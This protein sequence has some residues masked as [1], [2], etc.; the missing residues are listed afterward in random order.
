[1]EVVETELFWA[2]V[3]DSRR[4]EAGSTG[5]DERLR[6]VLLAVAPAELVRFQAGMEQVIAE[7]LTWNLW[8]AADR[9]FGGWCSDDTFAYFQRWLT[10][11]GRPTFEAVVADPDALAYVPEVRCLGGRPREAWGVA[12]PQ[13]ATLPDLA[14]AVYVRVT[15]AREE[16]FHSA[17][18]ALRSGAAARVPATPQGVRWSALDEPEAAR[19]LPRL[20]AMFPLAAA[21]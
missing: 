16:A 20:S 17:V 12:A 3:A 6:G 18:L 1:M 9:V 13:W 10:G 4:G 15:G 19:R 5:R 11:L 7:A 8:A 21:R 14:P 2:L